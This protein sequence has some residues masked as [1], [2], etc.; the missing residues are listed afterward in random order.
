MKATNSPAKPAITPVG[1]W[2]GRAESKLDAEP[3]EIVVVGAAA[4]AA[5]MPVLWL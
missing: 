2:N 4:A 1:L 3:A 5:A